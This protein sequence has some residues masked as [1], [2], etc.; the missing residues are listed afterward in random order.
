MA[1]KHAQLM[2]YTNAH[3]LVLHTYTTPGLHTCT[4][5]CLHTGTQALLLAY[6]LK[7]NTGFPLL[8][9]KLDL[10]DTLKLRPILQ[11][12]CIRVLGSWNYSSA[13]MPCF[14]LCREDW[15]C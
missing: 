7:F 14:L 9:F 5:H 1:S 15:Q 8:Y 6:A 4:S 2:A 10:A 3:P 12:S 13:S 11:S